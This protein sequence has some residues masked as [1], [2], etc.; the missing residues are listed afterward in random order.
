VV[1]ETG[2]KGIKN[3]FH[4]LRTPVRFANCILQ[5]K[6]HEAGVEFSSFFLN[7]LFGLGGFVDLAAQY[8]PAGISTNEDLGQTLGVWGAGEGVYLVWPLL[9]PSNV[10]DSMGM[11]GDYFIG[12]YSNPI[13]QFGDFNWTV[14]VGINALNALNSLGDILRAYDTFKEI[15]IDPYTSMRD[16][17]TQLRRSAIS[18]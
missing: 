14:E 12:Y 11:V 15:A 5:G 2:R 10:R 13:T 7:T 9:G 17:Y 1:P 8:K 6:G 4:N 3:F 16:G 18:K